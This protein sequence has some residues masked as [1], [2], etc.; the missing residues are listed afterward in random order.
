IT[1]NT[2]SDVSGVQV[3]D[4]TLVGNFNALA[5]GE[6]AEIT[7]NYVS[8]DTADAQLGAVPG[9]PDYPTTPANAVSEVKTVTLLVTGTNDQPVIEAI[10]ATGD[11]TELDGIGTGTTEANATGTLTISD[12][13]DTDTVTLTETYN[14]DMA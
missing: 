10:T 2:L 14:S 13:D 5:A 11:L 6:T 9:T 1:F 4:Y 8:T 3:Y 7:F 12:L